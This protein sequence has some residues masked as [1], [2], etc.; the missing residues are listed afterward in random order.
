MDDMDRAL[1]EAFAVVWERVKGDEDEL[2]ARLARR[3]GAEMS[4]PPRAWCL[5]VRASDRRIEPY[6]M[7]IVSYYREGVV[8][9]EEVTLNAECLGRLC[10]PV[11]IDEG[12][13][14]L[15]N[16][17][18]RL[19]VAQAS[20]TYARKGGMFRERR[21][22][23]FRGLAPIL[24]RDGLIDPSAP[25]GRTADRLWGWAWKSAARRLPADFAQVVERWPEYRLLRGRRVARGWRWK[26]PG[27]GERVR[28]IFLPVRPIN[29]AE[30]YGVKAELDGELDAV[31]ELPRVFGCTRCH[32][33]RYFSRV[34]RL[35]WNALIAHS[36]GGLLYG[37]EVRRPDYWEETRRR[38]YRRSAGRA[39]SKRRVEVL[40]LLL[41]GRTIKEIGRELGISANTVTNY[42]RV[43]YR[44]AGVHSR[45]ELRGKVD[46]SPSN[47]ATA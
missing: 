26:C 7:A 22:P 43:I 14:L 33:V 24:H 17:A 13:E 44:E 27:C 20:L 41:E 3:R 4:R 8:E 2:R 42:V 37:R 38:T 19:G 40:G 46:P 15:A 9:R 29:L 28:V 25:L 21:A 18:E 11:E 23:R 36:T 39:P 30:Y 6:R 12:G 5:A 47:S 10:A 35:G 1:V 31:E 34:G 16:V 45:G 32:R